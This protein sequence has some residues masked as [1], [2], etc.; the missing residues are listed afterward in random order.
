MRF[1]NLIV[2]HCSATC[3]ACSYTEHDLITDHRSQ[4]F[5][6]AGYHYYIYK[7]GDIKT[8]RPLERSEER[9][10]GYNAHSINI[11]C[12]SGLDERGRLVATRTDFQKHSLRM[13]VMLLLRGYPG[14]RLCGQ[15]DLSPDFNLNG[16]IEPEECIKACLCFDA[17]AILQEPPPPNPVSL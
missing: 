2:I 13:L 11:C 10:C 9:A 14:S 12:E 5:S 15:R 17:A 8:L 6:G 7:N 16:E 1:T 3:C 4:S